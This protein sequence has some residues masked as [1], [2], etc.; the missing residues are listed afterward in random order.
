[1]VSNPW[2]VLYLFLENAI[3]VISCHLMVSVVA[4]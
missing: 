2:I 1:M 4:Y 3:H